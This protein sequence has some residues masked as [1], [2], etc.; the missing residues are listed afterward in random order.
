MPEDVEYRVAFYATVR[1]AEGRYLVIRRSADSS[2]F[3]GRWE[4]P[5]GKPDPGETA[6][7]TVKRE[8]EEETGLQIRVVGLA[9]CTEFALPAFR[10]VMLVFRC[11]AAGEDVTLSDEHG[12]AEWVCEED[13]LQKDLTDHSRRFLESYLARKGGPGETI[14]V[15]LPL[16]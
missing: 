13:I 6:A 14:C 8:V 7:Q 15:S 3:A 9:G 10:V 11:I 1:D 2:H 16:E 5:G 12:A 4:I